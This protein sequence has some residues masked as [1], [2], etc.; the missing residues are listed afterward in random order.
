LNV[1]DTKRILL[2]LLTSA[3]LLG[4][5]LYAKREHILLGAEAYLFGYPLVIMDVTRSNS[6]LTI[7]PENQLRR[8]RQFPDANFRDVVRPNA[9]TTQPRPLDP[10]RQCIGRQGSTLLQHGLTRQRDVAE[11]LCA[12]VEGRVVQRCHRACW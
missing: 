2:G 10:G 8:V 7:G 3:L 6:A 1:R 12:A 9:D 4:G 11:P 5:T